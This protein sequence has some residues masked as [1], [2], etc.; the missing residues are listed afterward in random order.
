MRTTVYG[1]SDD[2][3]EIEGGISEEFNPSDDGPNYLAFSNGTVLGIE[4]TKLGVWKIVCFA[5]PQPVIDPAGGSDSDNYSDRAHLEDVDWVVF[6]N[7][8]EETKE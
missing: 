7:R 2:L 4:Y 5:G 6:G 1:A 8:F 3:V